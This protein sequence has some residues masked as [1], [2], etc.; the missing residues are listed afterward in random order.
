MFYFLGRPGLPVVHDF[1]FARS[2]DAPQITFQDPEN[3]RI[4]DCLL[5]EVIASFGPPVQ[6]DDIWPPYEEYIFQAPIPAGEP[7]GFRAIFSWN[8][9]QHVEWI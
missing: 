8:L 4:W 5:D 1:G 6:E 9:L 3:L 7:R 2:P